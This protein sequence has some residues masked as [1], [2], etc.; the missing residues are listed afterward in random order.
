[1]RIFILLLTFLTTSCAIHLGKI[2]IIVKKL[3]HDELNYEE[4]MQRK[5]QSQTIKDTQKDCTHVYLIVPTKLTL[6]L[7]GVFKKSCKDSN[8]SFDNKIYDEFFYFIYGRECVVNE[9]YCEN[10]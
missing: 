4:L 7:E 5:N 3:D 2:P 9:A 10:T 1:M 8:F 6:D